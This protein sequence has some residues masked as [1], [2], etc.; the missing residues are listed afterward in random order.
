[1]R[2]STLPD[3]ARVVVKQRCEVP[4]DFFQAEARG[5]AALRNARALRVPEVFEVEDDRIV[6]E[7][8]GDG[9]RTPD[10]W[11]HAGTGL[12]RQHSVIGTYF[13]FD[14]DGYCGDS[15]QENTPGDDGWRFF[16]EHR[17]L[18]QMRRAR[19]ACLVET[20]D[21]TA[22]ESICANLRGRVPDM[23][24]ILLHGDLWSATCMSART[25]SPL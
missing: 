22:I 10:Y 3:G 13:G 16:A 18:P 12:A 1:M 8:L 14:H 7:D 15:P 9:P 4:D 24:P 11:Q 21:S 19:N 5:L 23:P 17:L 2:R 25:A 20:R 6:L